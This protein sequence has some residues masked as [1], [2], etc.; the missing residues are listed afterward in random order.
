MP[1]LEEH[2]RRSRLR[3]NV[4]GRDIHSWLDE[5]SHHYASHHREFRHDTDTVRTVGELFGSR[6]GKLIAEN[7]ALDHIMADHEED[8][9]RRNE[10]TE[11]RSQSETMNHPQLDGNTKKCSTCGSNYFSQWKYCPYCQPLLHEKEKRAF[12]GESSLNL[13]PDQSLKEKYIPLTKKCSRCGAT[14]FVKMVYCPFCQH[15]LHEQEKK[16]QGF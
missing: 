14:F 1:N 4:E 11:I 9:R 10:L 2:C 8:I 6:Y 12:F 5:P 15:E 16:R 13:P 7:I 3:Y